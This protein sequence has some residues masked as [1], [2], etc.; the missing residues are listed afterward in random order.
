MLSADLQQQIIQQLGEQ[1][2]AKDWVINGPVIEAR[3]CILYK[4]SSATYPPAIAIKVYRDRKK[5]KNNTMPQ[6]AALE[7]FAPLLNGDDS[8]YR[9]P[10]A[11]GS[12]PEQRTFLMEWVDAPSLEH[13]LWRYCYHQGRQQ[14]GMRRTFG[15][16]RAFHEQAD[17]E[18]KPANINR[19]KNRLQQCIERHEGEF[20]L[21]KNAV[22]H[23]GLACITNLA[24]QFEALNV[25]HARLHGD[26]TPSN[27]LI[28]NDAVTAIDIAGA[29]LLPV[30]EDICLQLSY[31]AIGYPN[32]LTRGD[33]KKPPSQWPLLAVILE[34]Y[35]YPQDE[36]QRCFL[37]YVFLYQLLRRWAVIESR[38][39]ERRTP[40]VDR[41][42]LRNSA[43]IVAGVCRTLDKTCHQNGNRS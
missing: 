25:A 29:Q 14:H 30:A 11:Y 17:H 31:I 4:A 8:E 24:G 36:Q 9:V 40:L 16:L 2:D 38:N 7:R 42:R 41:W 22:F 5:R 34:A 27:M 19:Y 33:M 23:T 1:T 28:G 6:Y 3:E 15:W 20:L 12:F 10:V 39:K 37:L 32:M 21:V 43:M 13:R 35:G 26:F 18:V